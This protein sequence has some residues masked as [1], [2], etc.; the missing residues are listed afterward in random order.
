MGFK[1]NSSTGF[2]EVYYSAR[3]PITRIPVTLRRRNVKTEAE[4]RRVERQLIAQVHEKLKDKIVP[5]WKD[6]LEG[7]LESLRNRGYTHHTVHDYSTSLYAHTLTD[8]GDKRVDSITTEEIRSLIQAKVGD[9]STGHQK[10]VLKFIRGVFEYCVERGSL[11]RNPTPKMKFRVGDKLKGVLTEEQVRILLNRAKE[12]GIEWYPHWSMALYTGMRSGELYAL[13]WDKVNLENR[14]V[15][16]D[17]SWSS[18]DGFKCTKSGHDR[19]LEIAP[20]LLPMLKELKLRSGESPYVLPRISDWDSGWQ[21]RELR[22]FLIGLGLPP[23]RFHDLRATWATLLLSK[24]VE[25]IRVM[26]M[27]GWS[28]MKTMMVYVRKAGVDIRG[29]TDCL[30]LHNPSTETA[31]VLRMPECSYP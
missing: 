21:A 3:H 12:L 8:W 5:R 14:Q 6:A 16:V 15:K 28:D 20:P 23:V 31:T 25:P 26:K 7:F 13:T 29:A 18:K 30:N 27:G 2:F 24:G 11:V 9:R 4:A 19:I 17:T 22:R 10:N 1:K